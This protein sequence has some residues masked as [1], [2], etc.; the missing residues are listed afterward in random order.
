M[1]AAAHYAGVLRR[2]PTDWASWFIARFA[3][4]SALTGLLAEGTVLARVN[5]IVR[6]FMLREPVV[7]SC[8]VFCCCCVFYFRFAGVVWFCAPVNEPHM[9]ICENLT[10][11]FACVHA[12]VC[13]SR[14]A[15]LGICLLRYFMCIEI[16][17]I[18]NV[19]MYGSCN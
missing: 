8:D 10:F 16:N 11:A 1:I 9:S 6:L 3:W 4:F 13:V 19:L 15:I 17:W 14:I 18:F 12:C 2:R 5:K 7:G